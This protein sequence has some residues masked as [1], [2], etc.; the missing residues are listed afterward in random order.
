MA[1]REP[2]TRRDIGEYALRQPII[3]YL[4]PTCQMIYVTP[5]TVDKTH[6]ATSALCVITDMKMK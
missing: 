5:S 6:E 4:S 2:E 1:S 3:F